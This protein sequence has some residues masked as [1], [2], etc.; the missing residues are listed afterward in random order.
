MAFTNETFFKLLESA[1][2]QEYCQ[3]DNFAIRLK[4]DGYIIECYKW[5][6]DIYDDNTLNFDL[7][8]SE[9]FGKYEDMTLTDYQY[10]LLEDKFDAMRDD[11]FQRYEDENK[12]D[13][14]P[15]DDW[16]QFGEEVLTRI[17]L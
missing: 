4:I 7:C 2:E 12:S 13:Y 14:E 15:V 11:W 8:G 9:V 16:E 5:Y 6:G 1:K 10:K 3:L 17:R